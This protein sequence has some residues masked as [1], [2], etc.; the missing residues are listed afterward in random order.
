MNPEDDACEAILGRIVAM[1][2]PLGADLRR[3][4][5]YVV[6]IPARQRAEWLALGVPRQVHPALGGALLRFEGLEPY[7]ARTG[8]RLGAPLE[9]DLGSSVF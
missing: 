2:G 6:A 5:Q 1:E 8:V 7:D 9:R 3:L 4:Q